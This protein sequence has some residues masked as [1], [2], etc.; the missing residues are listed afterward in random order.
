MVRMAGLPVRQNQDSRPQLANDARDFQPVVVGV[1][2]PAVRNIQRLPP[3]G[4]EDASRLVR[5]ARA[6][7][8]RTARAHLALSE[9]EN[10][11]AV[12]ALGHLQQRAAAGLLHVVAMGSDGKNISLIVVSMAG[13]SLIATATP[14][15]SGMMVVYQSGEE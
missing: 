13:Y 8:D 2:D 12:A 15:R 14:S 10:R 6:I 3:A 9:I 4:F 5:F 11:S 7:F 1:L